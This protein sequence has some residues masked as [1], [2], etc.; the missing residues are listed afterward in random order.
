MTS[1]ET[2]PIRRKE[3][4]RPAEYQAGLDYKDI[5]RSI[6]RKLYRPSRT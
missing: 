6:S 1:T 5:N 3:K 2:V 4:V